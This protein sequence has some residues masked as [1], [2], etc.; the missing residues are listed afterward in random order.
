MK[1]SLLH[2]SKR[3]KATKAT[4]G[5]GDDR[6]WSITRD[7]AGNGKAIIRFLDAP[8][9]EDNEYVTVQYYSFKGPSGKTYYEKSL[10]TIGKD[11]P[12]YALNS[13]LYNSG[14]KADEDQAKSQRRVTRYFTNILVIKDYANPE[15]NGKVFLFRFGPQ[16]W[17]LMKEKMSPTKTEF[18]DDNTEGVPLFDPWGGCNVVLRTKQ[19]AGYAN[20]ESSEFMTPEPIGDDDFIEKI[21]SQ[22]YSLEEFLKPETFKT[23]DELKARLIEVLSESD[24]L[25][26][27]P[28]ASNPQQQK[29]APKPDRDSAVIDDSSLDDNDDDEDAEAFFNKLRQ[30]G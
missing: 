11:D 2:W 7:K 20:Y 6:F 12:V 26:D 30:A 4:S 19:V 24:D 3:S 15:N 27:I 17:A 16:L 8:K 22:Q 29:S 13:K 18:E 23:Y 21:W 10:R 25:D 14:I 9:G 28:T 5:G 1:K